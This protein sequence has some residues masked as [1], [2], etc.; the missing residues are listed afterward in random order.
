MIRAVGEPLGNADLAIDLTGR[1]GDTRLV[2][3]GD[4]FLQTQLAVAENGDER[5]KH[6]D[7]S[8]C[9]TRSGTRHADFVPALPGSVRFVVAP[10]ITRNRIPAW[11]R[12]MCRHGIFGVTYHMRRLQ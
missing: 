8:W 11:W 2:T 6:G 4:D 7:P 5:N 9:K 12:K 10:V 3:V 1:D